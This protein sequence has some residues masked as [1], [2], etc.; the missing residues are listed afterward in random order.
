MMKAFSLIEIIFVIV[1]LG[2]LAAVVIPKFMSTR[3]DANRA[4][5]VEDVRNATKEVMGYYIAHGGNVDF[6]KIKNNKGAIV[7]KL[8]KEG[9]VKIENSQKAYVYSNNVN[10]TVCVVY[11][12]DGNRIKLD[13][14]KSNNDPICR[15]IKNFI[16]NHNISILNNLVKF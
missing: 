16:N 2:I 13:I 14:N 3:V 8:I 9:W 6:N 12:T 10:K 4:K 11:T 15:R 7:N 1:I 5:V